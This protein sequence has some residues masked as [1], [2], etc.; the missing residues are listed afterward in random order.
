MRIEHL[1]DAHTKV[2]EQERSRNA[3]DYHEHR[4]QNFRNVAKANAGE[5]SKGIIIEPQTHGGR[6]GEHSEHAAAEE[7]HNGRNKLCKNVLFN[8]YRKGKHKIAFRSQQVFVKTNDDDDEGRYGKP[9]RQ[10]KIY[11]GKA[12]SRKGG[13]AV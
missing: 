2:V 7:P 11:S 1:P 4:Q 3:A 12:E 10:K 13:K 6:N 9:K 5:H 8:T